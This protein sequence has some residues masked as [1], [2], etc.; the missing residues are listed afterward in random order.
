MSRNTKYAIDT[1]LCKGN[2]FD[3]ENDDVAIAMEAEAVEHILLDEEEWTGEGPFLE[4]YEDPTFPADAR[5]LYFDPY[6][7]PKGALN[8]SSVRWCSIS[9]GE[10]QDCGNPTTYFGDYQS[11]LIEQGSLGDGYLINAM[12]LLASMCS[13]GGKKNRHYIKRL[14][15]SDRYAHRG[16][17]TVK[18]CKAGIWRYCHVDDRVPCRPSGAALFACNV[19]RDEVYAC[20]IE[21]AYAKMHGCYEGAAFGCLEKAL[22]ELTHCGGVACYRAELIDPDQVSIRNA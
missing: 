3:A 22:Q 8:G 17:Y 13:E 14:I 4:R 2:Y 1:G 6:N 7:P 21:K 10:L 9:R 12:R 15:V 16:I 5:S 11:P 19:N 20:I 18:I